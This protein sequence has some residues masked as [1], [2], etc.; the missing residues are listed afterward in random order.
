MCN[1]NLSQIEKK[2]AGQE[3][4]NQTWLAWETHIFGNHKCEVSCSQ[5]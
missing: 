3:I 5:T 1:L 2:S 4:K